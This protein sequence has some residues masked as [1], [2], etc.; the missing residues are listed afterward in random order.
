[1][2]HPS[3]QLAISVALRKLAQATSAPVPQ[4]IREL[5]VATA[6]AEQ[7]G[8][9]HVLVPVDDHFSTYELNMDPVH[10]NH[11]DGSQ[12]LTIVGKGPWQNR[13]A[14]RA[15][16]HIDLDDACTIC[17]MEAHEGEKLCRCFV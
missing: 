7:A 4:D 6:P 9:Y 12:P 11:P 2:G 10:L 15:E 13:D 5:V 16:H 14:Y 1:V 3:Q 17:Q 8:R